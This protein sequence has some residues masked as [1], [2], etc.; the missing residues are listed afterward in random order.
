MLSS[1]L[2]FMLV[3]NVLGSFVY[4]ARLI[5]DADY[6]KTVG[7]DAFSLIFFIVIVIWTIKCLSLL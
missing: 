5:N 7:K 2:W 4:S 1:Y 3:M 6:Y